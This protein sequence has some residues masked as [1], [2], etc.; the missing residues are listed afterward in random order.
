MDTLKASAIHELETIVENGPT[1]KDL[2]KIKTAQ[3][4]KRKQQIK[5][6]KFWLNLLMSADYSDKDISK[7]FDYEKDI[8]ALTKDQ[9]QQVAKKY[10]SG[11]YIL[12]IHNPE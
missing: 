12:C 6:N 3:I 2:E 5:E 11:G 9:I 4:L 7:V 1:D 10:L 8:N